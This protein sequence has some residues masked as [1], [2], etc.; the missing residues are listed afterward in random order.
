MRLNKH[1]SYYIRL[2]DGGIISDTINPSEIKLELKIFSVEKSYIMGKL[3]MKNYERTNRIDLMSNLIKT[4]KSEAPEKGNH[5]LSSNGI[6]NIN[7]SKTLNMPMNA[8]PSNNPVSIESL[9]DWRKRCIIIVDLCLKSLGKE[10]VY[11]EKPFDLTLRLPC[12]QKLNKLVD[13]SSIR[14]MLIGASRLECRSYSTH[15]QFYRD[16]VLFWESFRK[17][18][19]LKKNVRNSGFNGIKEFRNYWRHYFV[20]NL[21]TDFESCSRL[22][23]SH[24]DQKNI[25]LK[26]GIKSCN[27]ITTKKVIENLEEAKKTKTKQTNAPVFQTQSYQKKF[28]RTSRINM[29]KA[30]KSIAHNVDSHDFKQ[31]LEIFE[32]CDH[33]ETDK[34]GDKKVNL[35]KID[36][37]TLNRLDKLMK[38][39]N[40]C[41]S[42]ARGN[43]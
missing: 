20:C 40:I 18:K 36:A 38:Y 15:K 5:K 24:A 35:S 31:L 37:A 22:F 10:K 16:M 27:H 7:R 42:R 33:V 14:E 3:S 12:N 30:L 13:I 4:I 1:S 8:L 21:P 28:Q 41:P 17:C 43:Q 25:N 32:K 11:F 29:F 23:Q 2:D 26:S 19:N 6:M 39:N 9:P 34:N